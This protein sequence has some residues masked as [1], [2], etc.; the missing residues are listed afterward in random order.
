[1]WPNQE[2]TAN[3]SHL[4]NKSLIFKSLCSFRH[5]VTWQ[6]KEIK[7]LTSQE[8]W[9]PS[10]RGWWHTARCSK[11]DHLITFSCEDVQKT[12][13]HQTRQDCHYGRRLPPMKLHE[14]LTLWLTW[15]YV[16]YWKKYISNLTR[17]MA[18]K[19]GR[20]LTSSRRLRT[21]MYP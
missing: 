4:L 8:L 2:E 3:W 5:E 20:V 18:T 13:W 6:I 11:H 15:G 19:L 7:Y 12:Y 21:Q 14:L 9:S 16:E 1:M 17:L 10:L